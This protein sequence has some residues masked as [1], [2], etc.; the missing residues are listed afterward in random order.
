MSVEINLVGLTEAIAGYQRLA[1][2]MT[3]AAQMALMEVA[4]D[5]AEDAR[6]NAPVK[7]G[8]LRDS[9]ESVPVGS[10]ARVIAATPYAGFVEFGTDKMEGRAFIGR[11]I[12]QNLGKLVTA[13]FAQLDELS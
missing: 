5:I 6:N 2:G 1:Q 13:F 7:T 11:A 10:G 8:R 9:I 12:D 4:E 3:R